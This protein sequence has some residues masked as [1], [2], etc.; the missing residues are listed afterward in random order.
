VGH[1]ASPFIGQGEGT[2]YMRERERGGKGLLGSHRPSPPYSGPTSP[3]DD[4]GD[5]STSWHR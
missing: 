3:M 4:D 5:G 1:P 2:S